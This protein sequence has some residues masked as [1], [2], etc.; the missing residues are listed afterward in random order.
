MPELLCG[1]L[2]PTYRR[3]IPPQLLEHLMAKIQWRPEVNVLTVPQSYKI[4]FVPRDS[5]GTDDLA[6]AMNEENSN[7]S[8]ED[9]KTMLA[10][11][12]RVAQKK[13]LSGDQVT[14]DG[15]LTIGFSFTGRLDSPDD[16]LPPVDECLHVNVRVLQPFLREIRQQARFEKLPMIEKVPVIDAA[17]D[18]RLHLADVLYSKGVLNLS[19]TNL[20]FNPEAE[21]CECL[22]K[23]R[24]RNLFLFLLSIVE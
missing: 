22:L 2:T 23:K 9:V 16:P 1:K 21:G 12:E 20:A 8:V 3:S 17:E 5:A 13:L 15:M 11:Q 10:L 7:Y 6:V 4:R 24:W 14:I 19:G 18:T